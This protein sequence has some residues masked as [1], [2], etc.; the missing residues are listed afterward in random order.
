MGLVARN[1]LIDGIDEVTI[2]MLY[3]FLKDSV[4]SAVFE[5]CRTKGL[6]NNVAHKYV[7]HGCFEPIAGGHSVFEYLTSRFIDQVV[8]I[9]F[10]AVNALGMGYSGQD[11]CE[12]RSNGESFQHVTSFGLLGVIHNMRLVCPLFH[13]FKV[14]QRVQ[15]TKKQQGCNN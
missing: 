6:R 11:N 5:E 8:K 4:N 9:Q 7:P 14:I 3:A 1:E 2:G 15:S 12:G 13:K 10:L